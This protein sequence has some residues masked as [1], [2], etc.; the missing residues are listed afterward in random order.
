[1]SGRK[2]Q[3]VDPTWECGTATKARQRGP[4]WHCGQ[5]SMRLLIRAGTS[6]DI[7]FSG[8]QVSMILWRSLLAL[9]S[10]AVQF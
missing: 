2:A 1:M 6:Q 10:K 4:T 5:F 8:M 3:V 9:W 7:I